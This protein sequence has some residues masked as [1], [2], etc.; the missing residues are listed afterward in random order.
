MQAKCTNFVFCSRELSSKLRTK[1]RMTIRGFLSEFSVEQ[2]AQFRRIFAS[3]RKFSEIS[4]Q[5][6]SVYCLLL[7]ISHSIDSTVSHA[8]YAI[9]HSYMVH[10]IHDRSSAGVKSRIQTI[11]NTRKN[12]YFKF[13][14]IPEKTKHK[15]VLIIVIRCCCNSKFPTSAIFAPWTN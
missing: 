7:E 14:F 11:K 15:P 8:I 13:G 3:K 12:K 10:E 1:V 6:A 9:Y 4:Q 5:K 2:R